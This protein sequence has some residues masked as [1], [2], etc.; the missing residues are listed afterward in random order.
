MGK[1]GKLEVVLGWGIT[2]KGKTVGLYRV[3][4]RRGKAKDGGDVATM[5]GSGD[6][7]GKEKNK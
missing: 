5:A 6:G 2:E 7:Y 1:E 3:R 4:E